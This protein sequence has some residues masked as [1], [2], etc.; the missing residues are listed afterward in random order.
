M[1][2]TVIEGYEH[3]QIKCLNLNEEGQRR[4]PGQYV[5]SETLKIKKC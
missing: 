3:T 5:Q 4:P 1:P 2:N